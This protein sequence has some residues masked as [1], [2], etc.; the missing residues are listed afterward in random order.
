MNKDKVTVRLGMTD[1]E[2]EGGVILTLP[3]ADLHLPIEHLVPLYLRPAWE[4]ALQTLT[5]N[6]QEAAKAR[7]KSDPA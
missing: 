4:Q 5:Y 2:V 7:T 6:Q 3:A 1:G